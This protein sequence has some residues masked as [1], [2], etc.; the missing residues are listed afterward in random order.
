MMRRRKWIAVEILP[1]ARRQHSETPRIED[2]ALAVQEQW[3]P[4]K[5]GVPEVR[6]WS[7]RLKA[8]K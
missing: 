5:D 3:Q 2:S 4:V 7:R 1:E 8:E 6:K